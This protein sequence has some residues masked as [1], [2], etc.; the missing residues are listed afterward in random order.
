[1]HKESDY[2]EE[3]DEEGAVIENGGVYH[4]RRCEHEDFCN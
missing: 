3:A 2:L 4:H 1:M